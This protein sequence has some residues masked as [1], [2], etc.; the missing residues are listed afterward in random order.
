MTSL[1]A[2]IPLGQRPVPDEARRAA[3]ATKIVS[4]LRRWAE[5]NFVSQVHDVHP[6]SGRHAPFFDRCSI[7]NA[8]KNNNAQWS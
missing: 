1:A 3:S 4:V 6:V 5:S 8:W 7:H 2:L